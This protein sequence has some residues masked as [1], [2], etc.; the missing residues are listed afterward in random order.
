MIYLVGGTRPNFIKIAPLSRALTKYNIPY[1]IIHTGQHYDYNM[2]K[3]FFDEFELKKPLVHLEVGSGPHGEQTAKIMKRF[4]RLCFDAPPDMV[5]VVGD[6]NST[7]ACA[8]VV[9]KFPNI[10]LGHVEAGGRSFDK[11]MPEEINRI[12]VDSI[13]DYLFPIINDHV[14][15]LINEGIPK[16]KIYLVGDTIIDNLFYTLSKIKK[17]RPKQYILTTIHRAGNTDNIYVLKKILTSLNELSKT[18]K[19]KF[20]IHPR[21]RKIIKDNNLYISDNIEMIDPLGYFDFVKAMTG[22]SV[23]ITDSGGITIEAAILK[24]PCVVVRDTLERNFLIEEGKVVL[25][26]PLDIISNVDLVIGK[27]RQKLRRQFRIGKRRQKLRR[28]F[29][30][31]L[32]GKASERIIEYMERYYVH[33]PN[34]F[35]RV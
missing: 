2:D 21:T 33:T 14:K 35:S 16:E 34:I 27:R 25:S 23:I 12:I 10:T 5:F 29:S 3:I 15:N 13:S 18:S 30:Y 32:D 9:S 19:I 11:S 1:E 24:V 26:S 22:A 31:M 28:Q 6:V 20:P 17:I 4:E 7:L 8:L